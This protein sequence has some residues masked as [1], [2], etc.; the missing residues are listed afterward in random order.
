M[1]NLGVGGFVGSVMTGI[2]TS[3]DLVFWMDGTVLP[4][5][6]IDGYWNVLGYNLA[7]AA[8]IISWSMIVTMIILYAVDIIPGMKLR[9][10]QEDEMI[11]G[12]NLLT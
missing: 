12:C 9:Q 11:G 10:D 6:G 2:F 8:A 4:G 5:G 7:G 3:K 1:I